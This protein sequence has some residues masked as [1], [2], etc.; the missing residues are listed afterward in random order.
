MARAKAHAAPSLSAGT[1]LSNCEQEVQEAGVGRSKAGVSVLPSN[2]QQKSKQAASCRPSAS[3]TKWPATNDYRTKTALTSMLPEDLRRSILAKLDD[4]PTDSPVERARLTRVCARFVMESD[5]GLACR[6]AEAAQRLH[7][8]AE[9]EEN[10]ERAR[11][12]RRGEPLGPLSEAQEKA[13]AREFRESMKWLK[14]WAARCRAEA[15]AKQVAP[16]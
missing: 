14:Q 8:T 12:I 16:R 4:M 2:Q 1:R 15:R 9:G 6:M 11:A 10:L 3:L 7:P 5:T 13:H